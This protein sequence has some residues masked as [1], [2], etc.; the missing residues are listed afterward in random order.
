M[1]LQGQQDLI[2]TMLKL[3][4]VH[5]LTHIALPFLLGRHRLLDGKVADVNMTS[6]LYP[7]CL[8]GES[9]SGSQA[10]DT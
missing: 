2:E 5:V 7:V 6:R 8:V 9:P 3:L 4:Q 10:A 1:S